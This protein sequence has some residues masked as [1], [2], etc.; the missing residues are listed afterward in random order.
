MNKQHIENII[1]HEFKKTPYIILGIDWATF[2]SYPGE[3]ITEAVIKLNVEPSWPKLYRRF[4]RLEGKLNKKY[5]INL[6]IA[7]E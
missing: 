2:E 6:D 1:R 3:I 5:G 7:N 4:S